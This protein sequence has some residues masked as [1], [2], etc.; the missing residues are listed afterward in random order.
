MASFNTLIRKAA[1]GTMQI[2]REPIVPTDGRA[3]TNHRRNEVRS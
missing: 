2:S 1:D 3:K